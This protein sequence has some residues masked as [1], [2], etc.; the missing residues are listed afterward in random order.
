V[1]CTGE[2][3]PGPACQITPESLDFGS[4][5]MRK[6]KDLTFE[7]ENVGGG[8]LAGNIS[9]SCDDYSIVEGVGAFSLTAGQTHTVTVRFA[10]NRTGLISCWVMTGITA[11][12]SVVC[13]GVGL[14][15]EPSTS[16]K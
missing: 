13:Q 8:T 11:C 15:W 12:R 5:M 4:V 9:E 6:Y 16:G 2:G 10:P 3:T 7:I 14:R 1:S